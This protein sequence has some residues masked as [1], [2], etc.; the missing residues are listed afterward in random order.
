[1]TVKGAVVGKKLVLDITSGGQTRNERILLTKPPYLSPN[2]KPALVLLGLEQG[3]RFSFPLF[4]PATMNT[5]E[6]TVT[7]ESRERIKVGDQEKT[8]YKLRESFQGM[9]AFSWITQEGETIKEESALGYVLL[10][11]TRTES[12]KRDKRGPAIDIISLTMIPS[13]PIKDSSRVRHLKARLRGVPIT[14]FQ[15]QSDRQSLS[16]DVVEIT[17]P[18]PRC[19]VHDPLRRGRIFMS[20]CCRRH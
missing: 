11:E 6:A 1:M 19:L 15:L 12:L 4:N 5:E 20:T 2:I 16:G 7:V 14:G 9:E 3:K 18:G 13:D 8:V 10:R 17:R